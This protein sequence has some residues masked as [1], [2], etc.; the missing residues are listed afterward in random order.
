[1]LGLC[2]CHLQLLGE[3]PHYWE[4]VKQLDLQAK[5]K[6]RISVSVLLS[7]THM[8]LTMFFICYTRQI[9]LVTLFSKRLHAL[10]SSTSHWS[11]IPLSF[12]HS[13][14]CSSSQGRS[15]TIND[16]KVAGKKLTVVMMRKHKEWEYRCRGRSR[17]RRRGCICIPSAEKF[18]VTPVT[19]PMCATLSG[20]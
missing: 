8:W 14:P 13:L 4:K 10:L 2:S 15:L 9:C 11:R 7:M 3:T 1:M 16:M 20:V 17:S 19:T 18:E 12:I 5:S 6:A